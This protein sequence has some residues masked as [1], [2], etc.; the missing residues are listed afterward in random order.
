MSGNAEVGNPFAIGIDAWE[1]PLG[2]RDRSESSGVLPTR[3]SPYLESS[4]S[5]PGDGFRKGL[6]AWEQPFGRVP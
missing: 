1:D 2:E 5:K 4:T 3:G 6:D